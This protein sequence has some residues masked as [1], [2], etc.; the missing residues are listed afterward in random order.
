MGYTIW[1]TATGLMIEVS[2]SQSDALFAGARVRRQPNLAQGVRGETS[3]LLA[4]RTLGQIL[5]TSTYF[6]YSTSYL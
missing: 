5:S 3:D 4:L 6:N 1:L 2:G